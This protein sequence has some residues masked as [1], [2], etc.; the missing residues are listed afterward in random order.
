MSTG[1]ESGVRGQCK[2]KFDNK[3]GQFGASNTMV[4]KFSNPNSIQYSPIPICAPLKA[5]KSHPILIL[6]G[7]ED[8]LNPLQAP[9][10][11]KTQKAIISSKPE[12]IV[13]IWG[14]AQKQQ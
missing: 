3:K 10:N 5:R 4:S 1:T 7:L 13:P 8:P 2:C 11:P 6:A 12:D 9:Q 14:P